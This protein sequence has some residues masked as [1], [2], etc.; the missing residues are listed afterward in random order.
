M[1]AGVVKPGKVYPKNPAQHAADFKKL[2]SV[3]E[4][5]PVF[6]NHCTGLPK[7]VACICVEMKTLNGTCCS[8]SDVDKEKLTQNLMSAAEVYIHRCNKAPC[9]DTEIHLYL[10]A[11][12]SELQNRRE[13]LLKFLITKGKPRRVF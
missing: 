3:L 8:G 5:E 4:L 1:C 11:D 9:G 13:R 10:G 2:A 6:S 12:S 7:R